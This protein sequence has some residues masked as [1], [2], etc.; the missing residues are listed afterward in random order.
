M[1]QRK[2]F[3]G[4]IPRASLAHSHKPLEVNECSDQSFPGAVLD[5]G[6]ARTLIGA[7]QAHCLYSLLGKNL[8]ARNSCRRFRFGDQ[9]VSSLGEARL[10]MPAGAAFIYITADVVPLQVPL[11]LGLDTMNRYDMRV[12]TRKRQLEGAGESGWSAPLNLEERDLILPWSPMST[13]ILFTKLEV[14]RTHRGFHHPSSKRLYDIF[15]RARPTEAPPLL[16]LQL[17]GCNIIR[18]RNY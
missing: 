13:G 14:V 15:R 9:V 8:R 4:V 3:H 16:R 7:R 1:R 17:I 12:C 10:R 18:L 11:L 5:T 6:A 2:N